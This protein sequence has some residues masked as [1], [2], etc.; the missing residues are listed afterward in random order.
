MKPTI[1]LYEG[2][3]TNLTVYDP[4]TDSFYIYEFE[5]VSGI[6][7]HNIKNRTGSNG[8]STSANV[9]Y[10]HI[11]LNHLKEVHQSTFS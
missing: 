11:I 2:H 5:R 9:Q 6:K 10:L 8:L 7:H 4:N 1:A 3:D